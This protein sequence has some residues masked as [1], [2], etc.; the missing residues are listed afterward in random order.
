MFKTKLT[1]LCGIEHPVVCGGMHFV[2]YAELA[3][4]VSNAGALGM[5]TGLTQPTPEALQAEIRKCKTMTSKPFGVNLTILPMLIPADYD[6]YIDVIAKEGVKVCEIT[7]GNPEKYVKLL[8]DAGVVVIHKSATI[9]HALKAQSLGVDII[10]VSG[11]ESATAG[12]QSKDDT[13]TWVVLAKA[14]EKLHTPIIV[15]GASATG[16]QLAAALAM[17]AHGI[18]MGTRFMCTQEA[19]IHPAI[20]AEI[21]RPEADEFSTCMILQPFENGTRVYKSEAAL[22]V[23]ELQKEDKDFDALYPYVKGENWQKAAKETGDW[24]NSTWSV[25]QSIGLIE[26]VPTCVDL[27]A[28]IVSDAEKCLGAATQLRVSKL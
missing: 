9:R 15:S 17:G 25:G 1:E 4:A 3:A 2:G 18:T 23:L 14:L 8:H 10:E 24:Q 7:G 26:D 20:K 12:R 19:P 21:S 16:R 6:T 22:K 27:V 11:Y 28:R 13:T 5:I